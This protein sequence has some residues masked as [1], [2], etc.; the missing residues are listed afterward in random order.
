MVAL[1][2]WCSINNKIGVA[3]DVSLAGIKARGP[4]TQKQCYFSPFLPEKLR[5]KFPLGQ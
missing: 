1:K 5:S 2:H 4:L 3:G